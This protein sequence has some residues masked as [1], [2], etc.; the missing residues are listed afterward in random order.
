MVILM[1][2]ES[3]FPSCWLVLLSDERNKILICYYG[4]EVEC[5]IGFVSMPCG[6]PQPDMTELGSEAVMARTSKC[7]EPEPRSLR[8]SDQV[9]VSIV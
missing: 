2:P 5:R 3:L 9:R 4:S 8:P 6:G 7:R 1:C